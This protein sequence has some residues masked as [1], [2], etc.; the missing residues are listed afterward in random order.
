VVLIGDLVP[1][2]VRTDL[3]GIDQVYDLSAY[4]IPVCFNR[5]RLI[6]EHL[7]HGDL[8]WGEASLSTA[9]RS[10]TEPHANERGG[11]ATGHSVS[12]R[13]ATCVSARTTRLR[14]NVGHGSSLLSGDEP[15]TFEECGHS[16]PLNTQETLQNIVFS[17][18]Q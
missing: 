8:H 1:D 3:A 14:R 17:T 16:V 11:N 9:R 13:P 4:F 12:G 6:A 7:N 18:T 10:R 2:L 5:H 15:S